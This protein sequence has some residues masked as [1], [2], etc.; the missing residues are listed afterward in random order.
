MR[1]SVPW[2]KMAAEILAE[3]GYTNIREFGGI[4]DWPY[5]VE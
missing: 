1:F 2:N 3:P 5:E 4:I